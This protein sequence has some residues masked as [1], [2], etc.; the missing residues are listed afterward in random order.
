MRKS[1]LLT[2]SFCCACFF[3]QCN[4]RQVNTREQF[5]AVREKFTTEYL[6]LLPDEAP[7]S[8]IISQP[9]KGRMFFVPTTQN[10][11]ILADFYETHRVELQKINLKDL[12]EVQRKEMQKMEKVMRNLHFFLTQCSNS[13]QMFDVAPLMRRIIRDSLL[14]DVQKMDIL[15]HKLQRVPEYYEAAKTVVANASP[16]NCRVAIQQQVLTFSFLDNELSNMFKKHNIDSF[17]YQNLMYYAK[18]SIKDYIAFCRNLEFE[19]HTANTQ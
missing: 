12:S 1:T 6:N 9:E 2:L 8:S 7:L 5:L 14:T 19:E 4:K 13:P 15:L 10:L 18:L 17:D 16:P 11:K 3:W